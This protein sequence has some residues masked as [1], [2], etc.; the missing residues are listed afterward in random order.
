MYCIEG[1]SPKEIGAFFGLNGHVRIRWAKI[2]LFRLLDDRSAAGDAD[3]A[4]IRGHCRRP[5]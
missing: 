5:R 1:Y 2:R 4:L 3:A